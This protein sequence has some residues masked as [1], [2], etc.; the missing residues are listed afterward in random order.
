MR[1]RIRGRTRAE[2][3]EGVFEGIAEN[4]Q[5]VP[6]GFFTTMSKTTVLLSILFLIGF[7]AGVF[8]VHS[9]NSSVMNMLNFTSQSFLD[10]RVHQSVFDTFIYSFSAGYLYVFIAFL[11]GFSSISAPIT[12]L[13]P[14]LKG[15]GLGI[16]M[17]FM[18]SEHGMNGFYYCLLLIVPYS[19]VA[20]TCVILSC[21]ESILFSNVFFAFLF[22]N[23]KLETAFPAFKVYLVK[24]L[25]ISV[26]VVSASVLDVICTGLF[27][28]IFV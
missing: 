18:Y 13:I 20:T 25:Y 9:G 17:A 28:G 6:G 2:I 10:K 15:I 5:K 24:F 23:S 7:T 21:K 11:L 8:I 4:I 26:A 14:P 22:T 16:A 12:L 3:K 1:K 19:L 27:A